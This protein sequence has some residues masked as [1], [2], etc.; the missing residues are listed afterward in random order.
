MDAGEPMAASRGY[1]THGVDAYPG[2]VAQ[3]RM[4][5]LIDYDLRLTDPARTVYRFLIGWYMQTRGD[6]LASVRHIVATMRARAP[7]GARHLSRSAVSRAILFLTETGW[8]VRTHTGNRAGA[9]RFVP[10]LNVLD[11]AA[12][13]TLPNAESCYVPVH[14]DIMDGQL[15]S[16]STGTQLSHST[17]TQKPDASHST[18]TKTLLLDPV[19]EPGTGNSNAV[20]RGGATAGLAPAALAG[21]ES[22]WVAYGKLGSKAAAKA[23]F[24]KLTDPDV[25]HITARATSWAASARPGQKRMPLEKWLALEKFD[26]ADRR[27]ESKPQSDA[28]TEGH[29]GAVRDEPPN[30]RAAKDARSWPTG[31]FIGRFIAGRVEE[32]AF[33][34][35]VVMTFR[36][37]AP[38]QSFGRVCDHRFWLRA[39]VRSYQT[40]GHEIMDGICAAL[41]MRGC[42][43]TDLLLDKPLVAVADGGTVHYRPISISEAA[44]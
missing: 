17:G 5:Q 27:V 20:S 43:D 24:D 22:I 25:A 32:D 14:R 36:I 29:E 26:E 41:K 35:A 11:L 19:K 40:A 7:D 21:F 3:F 12:Q 6:A 10:V 18:G 38:G 8:L 1:W 23:E 37:D 39:H 30:S 13:G 34:T 31:A 16:H 4:S 44:L 15:A 33:E 42:E 9:S 2:P 28:E